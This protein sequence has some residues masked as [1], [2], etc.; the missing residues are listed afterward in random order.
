MFWLLITV[1]LGSKIS[2]I[3]FSHSEANLLPRDHEENIKYDHF[4]EIFGEEGN[5]IIIAVQDSSLFKVD[6]FNKWNEFSHK[7]D[8]FP[9]VDF[10]I[11]VGD[12]QKLK[13]DKKNQ[14]FFVEP[15]YEENPTTDKEVLEIRDELFENLPF[16]DNILFNKETGTVQTAIYLD[17]A[18]VNTKKR[19]RFVF[20]VLNPSVEAFE[21]E[22]GLDVRVSGMPFI[23]TMNA[24]NII[25]EIGIFVGLALFIT[26]LIFWLFFRSYRATFIT[27]TVVS[28]GVVWALGF[29]G[30][31]EYEISVL[32][33][34][35]PPLII[36][37]G[38]PNAIFLI[39]KY[40]QEVKKH[41]NQAKSLQRVISKIGNATLMTN[42]TTASGFATFIFTNSQ[43]LNEFGIIASI[44]ILAIFIL[45]LLI[46]PII[47]SFMQKPKDK[48]LEHLERKWIDAIVDWMENTVRHH[49]MASIFLRCVSSLASI[50]G[51]YMIRVS[52][53]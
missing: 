47:Y 45:S 16:F 44:N 33:A 23:R 12:I 51:V 29:I 27:M 10:S 7:L 17:K 34:L 41:G 24:Q 40:Q 52:G 14:K 19:E 46:I 5:M 2:N 1:F 32:M 3:Q 39:N 21:K 49:R 36:V 9:E 35:I 4:L 50:I 30:W 43:L 42:I 26:S 22:T 11:S 8:S 37:I 15:I 20:E 13:K 53:V 28:I 38:V 18:I 48:H 6:N 25:D 31:F